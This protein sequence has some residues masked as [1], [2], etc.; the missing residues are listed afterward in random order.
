MRR[1]IARL[2]VA[3]VLALPLTLITAQ[4][5]GACDR[6]PC[7]AS[8]HVNEPTVEVDESGTIVVGMGYPLIECYY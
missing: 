7:H 5:A 6:Q 8:C 4:P 2:L 1:R 3:V